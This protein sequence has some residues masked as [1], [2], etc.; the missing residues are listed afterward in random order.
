MPTMLS[1]GM[2]GYIWPDDDIKPIGEEIKAPLANCED[3]INNQ[4]I[5]VKYRD[6]LFDDDYI[7]EAKLLENVVLPQAILKPRDYD[8]MTSYRPKTGF[9]ERPQYQKDL[10]PFRRFT[11]L[12]Y[13]IFSK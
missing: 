2:T 9:Q 1:G 5:C 8:Q 4:V 6:L 3:I 13:K 10:G 11:N 12:N 7:F